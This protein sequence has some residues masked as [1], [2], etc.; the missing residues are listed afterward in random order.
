MPQK[1]W[2]GK[3]D[4]STPAGRDAQDAIAAK[5][6]RIAHQKGVAYEL[7]SAKAREIAIKA[8]GTRTRDPKG[9]FVAKSGPTPAQ[10]SKVA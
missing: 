2:F 1:G 8:V 6:G 4:M 7:N 10:D 5:G 9:L 3:H